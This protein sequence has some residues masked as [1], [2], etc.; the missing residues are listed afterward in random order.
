MKLGSS[1]RPSLRKAKCRRP[2]AEDEEERDGPFA[3]RDRGKIEAHQFPPAFRC[4]PDARALLK[5]MSAERNNRITGVHSGDH[6][7]F[8]AHPNKL[9]GLKAY[10][11]GGAVQDPNAGLA[12]SSSRAPSGAWISGWL[13]LL[14]SRMV[15]VAPSGAAAASP[16]ST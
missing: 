16:S 14:A 4:S 6:G 9:H 12:P 13:A 2:P 15:T 11:R 5:E 8:A 1:A 10:G 7:G 3:N